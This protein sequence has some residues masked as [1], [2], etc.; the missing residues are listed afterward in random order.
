[1]LQS[2]LDVLEADRQKA[3]KE[4]REAIEEEKRRLQERASQAQ[5]GVSDLLLA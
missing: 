4:K 1:M 3:L 2:K 5:A